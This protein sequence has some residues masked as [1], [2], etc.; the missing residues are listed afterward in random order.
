MPLKKKQQQVQ[1][2]SSPAQVATMANMEDPLTLT[3]LV[4][5]LEKHKK[6]N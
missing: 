6:E 4:Q 1:E 3:S 2:A 5:E